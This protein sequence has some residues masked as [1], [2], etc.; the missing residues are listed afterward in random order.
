MGGLP[1]PG[2]K[3]GLRGSPGRWSGET[4]THCADRG[5]LLSAHLFFQDGG[6]LRHPLGTFPEKAEI[7]QGPGRE[8]GVC[9]IWGEKMEQ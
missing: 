2:E 7:L 4:A 6:H 1:C 5:C 8:G 3:V 9:C